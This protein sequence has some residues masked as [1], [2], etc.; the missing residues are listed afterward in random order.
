MKLLISAALLVAVLLVAGTGIELAAA[1]P[2]TTVPVKFSFADDPTHKIA[3]DLLGPYQDGS[4]V[5]ATIEP[6]SNGRLVIYW[7]ASKTVPSRRFRLTFDD[8]IGTCYD[9]PFVSSLTTAQIIAGVRQPDGTPGGLLTM[10]VG[11]TGF[12]AGVKM[13]LG[14]INSVHWT[15]CQTPGDASGFCA[16]S[17]GSTP[18]HIVRTAPASW[19]ISADP[20]PRPDPYDPD[21]DPRAG[22]E[23]FTESSSGR[24]RSITMQGEYAMPFAMTVQCVT[25]AN[26]R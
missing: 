8:C 7:R 10:P 26:C 2:Q 12:R 1:P 5:S 17:T 16:N 4:V 19:T 23:L 21:T 9:V 24:N 18:T 22:G 14:A 25:A 11:A 13:Y 3:S 6:G 20:E 15:L